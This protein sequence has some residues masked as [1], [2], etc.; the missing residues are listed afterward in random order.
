MF[1]LLK[2]H[3][4]TPS[5]DCGGLSALFS[6][7]IPALSHRASVGGVLEHLGTLPLTA[8]SSLA[9]VRLHDET[10]LLGITPQGVTLLT[11]GRRAEGSGA[12]LSSSDSISPQEEHLRLRELPAR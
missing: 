12:S 3:S 7:L 8:Q 2:K 1:R 10:L 9:L 6:R 4:R 11:K 5:G